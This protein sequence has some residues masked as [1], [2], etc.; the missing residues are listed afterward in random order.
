VPNHPSADAI[1]KEVLTR[2]MILKGEA[3]SIPKNSPGYEDCNRRKAVNRLIN[4]PKIALEQ[5]IF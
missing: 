2:A 1:N 5:D 3:H 4:T